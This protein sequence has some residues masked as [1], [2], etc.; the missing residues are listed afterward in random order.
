M[1]EQET[2][3]CEGECKCEAVGE[4]LDLNRS[5][6]PA[7]NCAADEAHDE[8]GDYGANQQTDSVELRWMYE[9]TREDE[10]ADKAEGEPEKSEFQNCGRRIRSVE[11]QTEERC[12]TEPAM[13]IRY[14]SGVF[15]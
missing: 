3:Q 14:S 7:A 10:N 6:S 15:S 4:A 2:E 13:R 12:E 9:W 8:A 5:L 11:D 1:H